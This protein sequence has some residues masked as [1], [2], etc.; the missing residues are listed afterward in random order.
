MSKNTTQKELDWLGKEIQKDQ[1][2]VENHK[3]KM[4]QQLKKTKKEDLFKVPEK[5]KPNKIK[6]LL[7]RVGKILG[8]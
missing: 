2:A 6:D 8:M 7:T 1:K 3:K 5:E 4:I